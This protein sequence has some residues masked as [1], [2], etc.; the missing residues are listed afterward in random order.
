MKS[1]QKETTLNMPPCT[2]DNVCTEV[3]KLLRKT[4]LR[5]TQA[6]PGRAS[7]EQQEQISPNL[8]RSINGTS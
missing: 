4:K 3:H 7:K 1:A 5:R 6:G 8:E 2:E